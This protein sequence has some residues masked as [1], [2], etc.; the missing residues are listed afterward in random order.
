MEDLQTRTQESFFKWPLTGLWLEHGR[1]H[2]VRKSHQ[3]EQSP[4]GTGRQQYPH[5][6]CYISNSHCDDVTPGEIASRFQRQERVE[7][8]KRD[9]LQLLGDC[10]LV[11]S[12]L[13]RLTQ[14]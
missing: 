13:T 3:E 12:G 7:N 4:S 9:E 8:L 11:C 6:D 1:A 10:A 5:R 2:V 14:F